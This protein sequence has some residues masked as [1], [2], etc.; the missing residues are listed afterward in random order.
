MR[1]S[2]WASAER[3]SNPTPCRWGRGIWD[4]RVS[5]GFG[6][7]PYARSG[8][9]R[10]AEQLCVASRPANPCPAMYSG[11]Q[12]TLW[13]EAELAARCPAVCDTMLRCCPA[14]S[15]RRCAA[16]VERERRV[17]RT[18]PVWCAWCRKASARATHPADVPTASRLPPG[19]PASADTPYMPSTWSHALGKLIRA[20]AEGQQHSTL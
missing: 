20:Q 8:T 15:D 17:M 11:P 6:V 13:C 7:Q 16:A 12:K 10:P 19:A 9:D 4:A 1:P 18:P 3:M 14:P 2:G 5:G